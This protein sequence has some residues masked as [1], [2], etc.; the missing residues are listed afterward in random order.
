M[1]RDAQETEVKAILLRPIPPFY[2]KAT[3]SQLGS[4]Q[5]AQRKG[6]AVLPSAGPGLGPPP[7]PV[8]RP[9]QTPAP[10]RSTLSHTRI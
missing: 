3:L 8:P 7:A 9:A 5:V 1:Q 6:E 4:S 10:G 2:L